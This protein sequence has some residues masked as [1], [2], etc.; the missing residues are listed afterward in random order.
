MSLSTEDKIKNILF[1]IGKDIKI[2]K[3][4]NI[5]MVIE[6]DYDKYVAMLNAVIQEE[7]SKQT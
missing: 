7:I 2:H 4:D 5:N 6:I 1:E 3:I